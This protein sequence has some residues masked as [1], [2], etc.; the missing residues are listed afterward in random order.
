MGLEKMTLP[1]NDYS[2]T[3]SNWNFKMLIFRSRTSI[4]TD[5]DDPKIRES[6]RAASGQDTRAIFLTRI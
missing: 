2:F 3:E 6:T 4:R 5:L 1:E